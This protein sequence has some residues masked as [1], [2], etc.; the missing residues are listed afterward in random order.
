LFACLSSG[1]TTTTTGRLHGPKDTTTS[2][3]VEPR[4]HNF[5]I[6]IPVSPGMERLQNLFTILDAVAP[7]T[8]LVSPVAKLWFNS[9]CNS[10]GLVI[11]RLRNLGST[12]DVF[13]VP[14][15]PSSLPVIMVAQPDKNMQT[16]S[17]C[18]GGWVSV[19]LL[20]K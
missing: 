15:G 13:V 11:E 8:S 1:W 4:F 7:I 5:S 19:Y 9:R 14:L 12:S 18:V 20:E 10:I 2:L 3:G 6:I 17:F 16:E